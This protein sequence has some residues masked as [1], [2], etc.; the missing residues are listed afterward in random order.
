MKILG[1]ESS[2]DET[3]VAI[4]EDGRK[5]RANSVASSLDLQTIYGG[6]VPEVAARS[7]L[8]SIIPVVDQALTN[9]Q[10]RLGRY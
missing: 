3:A 2:A 5:L 4:V 9:V 10:L 6:I 8:E 1:I 7:H